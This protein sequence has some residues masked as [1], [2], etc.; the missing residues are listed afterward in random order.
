VCGACF[1]QAGTLFGELALMYEVPRTATIEATTDAAYY[2]LGRE[3][4]RST[5]R[6]EN[7]ARRREAFT[8]LRSC[9]IFGQMG[10]RELSR[11]ADV[12]QLQPYAEGSVIVREADQAD[13]M[14]FIR[15]GQ[16]VV[17]QSIPPDERDAETTTTETLMRI[18]K[19]GDYFGERALLTHE[20]RSASVEAVS[21][22]VC[23]RVGREEF[24]KLF[25]PVREKFA[26]RMPASGARKMSSGTLNGIAK[27]PQRYAPRVES[28]HITKPLGS[29]GFARVMMVGIPGSNSPRPASADHQLLA[30]GAH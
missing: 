30:R 20:P 12:V 27:S 23:M 25:D 22:V 9:E 15:E 8:F 4:F 18:L 3:A 13:S 29:G 10:T 5:L 28:L 11:V 1:S 2:T 6:E 21:S 7:I 16:V 17:K 19:P 26:Q 24:L 14:Y